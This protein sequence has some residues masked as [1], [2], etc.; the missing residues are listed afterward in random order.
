MVN[1]QASSD[2]Y[3]GLHFPASDIPKQARD[4]Y[5]SNKIRVLYNRD[6][7]TSRLVCRTFDDAKRPLN[8]EHSYLRAMSPVHIK[9]LANMGVQASMSI[10]LVVNKKLW[11]LISCHTYGPGPGMRISLPLREVCRSLGDIASS[12]VEKLLYTS[13]IRARRPL[14]NAAPKTSPYSYIT[15]SSAELLNMFGADFGFLV[16][17]TEARTIGK[18]AGYKECITLLQYIRKRSF[19]T[20]FSS[21]AIQKDF[22][23]INYPQGFSLLAGYLSSH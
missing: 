18:L 17:K 16:I 21:N 3:R 10:S 14:I 7:E 15:S 9:Y 22:P 19:S 2:I 8:L 4:L 6:H 1:T 12:N 23:D 20:V 5:L 13:R 11:G